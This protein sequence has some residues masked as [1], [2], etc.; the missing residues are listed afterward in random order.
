MDKIPENIYYKS[1]WDINLVPSLYNDSFFVP[2][3]KPQNQKKR[4]FLNQEPVKS[5]YQHLKEISDVRGFVVNVHGPTDFDID[6]QLS[7]DLIKNYDS[8]I[9]HNYTYKDIGI[10]YEFP[11]NNTLSRSHEQEGKAYRCRLRGIGLNK[12]NNKSFLWK[13]NQ[14]LIEIIHLL[15]R[16]DYWVRCNLLDIDVYNRLLIDIMLDTKNGTINLTD[17]LLTRMKSENQPI[18]FE[19]V[20]SIKEEK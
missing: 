4:S 5:K 3:K 13:S 16:T 9:S 19:Y 7:N 14:L 17:Y 2:K 20:K 12:A 6:F 10:N 18:F 15:D 11:P 8:V 1:K